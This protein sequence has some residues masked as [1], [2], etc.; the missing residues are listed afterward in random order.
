MNA[1][2]DKPPWRASNP[3]DREWM[4][5]WVLDQLDQDDAEQEYWDNK[6]AET[7]DL[8]LLRKVP[9]RKVPRLERAKES[10]RQGDLAPLRQLFPQIA[11]FIAV[12]KRPRGQRRSYP[13][14]PIKAIK[15]YGQEPLVDDVK[16]VRALW[17]RY[18]K[19]SKRRSTD[20]ATAEEI[21]ARRYGCT[22]EKVAD[23]LKAH[24][25]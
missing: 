15:L 14:D 3:R 25:R 22:E 11:E 18:Y 17:K 16:R 12:P 20:G 4:I 5:V 7:R 24:S 6:L 10:A 1:P 8:E 13:R 21:V 19:P 2:C 23:A 9:V